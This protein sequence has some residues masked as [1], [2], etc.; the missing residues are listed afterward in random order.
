MSTIINLENLQEFCGAG[1]T[2]F[3]INLKQV[4]FT[5]SLCEL[6]LS[7]NL[8]ESEGTVSTRIS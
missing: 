8:P 6:Y 7:L 4:T 5:L 3:Q 2:V 1:L